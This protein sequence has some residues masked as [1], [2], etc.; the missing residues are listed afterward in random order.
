M[1]TFVLAKQGSGTREYN[2]A[3]GTR[4]AV[5]NTSSAAVSLGTLGNSREVMISTTTRCYINFG[6][7]DVA[8]ASAVGTNLLLAPD[9]IFHLRIPENVTHF[10]VIRES[11][12]GFVVVTPV[13]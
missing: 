8:A 4:T 13:L 10:R 2:F 12:D 3:Q 7:S 9:T 6:A 1:S 11:V 5:T